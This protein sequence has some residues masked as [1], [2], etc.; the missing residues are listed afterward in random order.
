MTGRS[1]SEQDAP[2]K[3]ERR[4][5][6]RVEGYRRS[7]VKRVYGKGERMTHQGQWMRG[8]D[9]GRKLRSKVGAVEA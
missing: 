8:G 3:R 2:K 1:C 4:H 6:H 5:K 7:Q 9:Q